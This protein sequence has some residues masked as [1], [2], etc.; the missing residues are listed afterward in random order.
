MKTL[1]KICGITNEADGL[2]AVEAGADYVGFVLY[3]KSSRY[4]MPDR[5]RE[6]SR[7]LPSKVK[8]VGVFVN[9]EVKEVLDVMDFCGLDIAQ[10]HGDETSEVVE[11]IGVDRVWKAVALGNT[12]DVERAAVYPA[13]AMLVDAMTRQ[14]RGGT[15]R[16]A[17]WG[18][19]AQLARRRKV[20]LAG[21]LTP[22]NVV[23]AVRQVAPYGVDV[24]S[25]VERVPGKKDHCL[26]RDMVRKVRHV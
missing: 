2:A 12:Q 10:L 22:L 18:L 21:G 25:G 24:S 11:K 16:L 14:T 17:D 1:I 4:V 9:A 19:A 26:I 6:L 7:A 23:D 20:M 3:P 5:L 13:A 15:G 8:K